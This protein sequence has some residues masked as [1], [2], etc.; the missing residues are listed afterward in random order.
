M[1]M[2][3]ITF[4]EGDAP[5][6]LAA[7]AAWLGQ[8]VED[9]S[10]TFALSRFSGGQSNPTFKL[11]GA[12][13]DYVLRTKPGAAHQLLRSAHAI[14][15]E[16]RIQDALFN[17][18]VPV[19]RMHALCEDEAIIGRAFYLMD[20]VEGR[21]F[22]DPSLPGQTPAQRAAIFDE[23]NRVIA[24]LHAVDHEALGLADYGKPGNYFTR[25]ISRWSRQYET[26]KTEDIKAM[27]DLMAWL[28]AHVPNEDPEPVCIVHGDFRMDNLVFH[29]TESRVIAILDW[30]LSTLG[31]P[32]ADFAYHCMAWHVLPTVFRGINGLDLEA[33]GIPQADDYVTRYLRRT[34]RAIAGDWNFYLAYNMFRMASILQGITKRMA[35][36][37]AASAEA[38]KASRATRPFA[39]LA[40]SFAS[41]VD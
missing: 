17:T 8:H 32:L 24:A 36:G 29:P 13:H 41:R 25:Q 31:H 28:P 35:D 39:E 37:T 30:E 12:K 34:G 21:I 27:D 1:A 14:E 6:D 38:I 4:E 19:A 20:F 11:S 15:R 9:F 40:W 33:L 18:D 10:G 22:W 16:Y 7:L 5:F 3:T 26:S 2:T 23:M